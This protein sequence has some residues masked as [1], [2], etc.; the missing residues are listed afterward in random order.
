M[1]EEKDIVKELADRLKFDFTLE[2]F[3]F[4]NEITLKVSFDDKVLFEKGLYFDK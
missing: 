1:D 3:P 2:K 4:G